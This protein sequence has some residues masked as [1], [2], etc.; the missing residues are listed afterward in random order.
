MTKGS[1]S[2]I[3]FLCHLTEHLHRFPI[4]FF[5]LFYAFASFLSPGSTLFSCLGFKPCTSCITLG[6]SKWKNSNPLTHLVVWC[7]KYL[8]LKL[9]PEPIRTSSDTSSPPSSLLSRCAL[10]PSLFTRFTS[11]IRSLPT[12]FGPTISSTHSLFSVL[13]RLRFPSLS[14]ATLLSAS[15]RRSWRSELDGR[16]GPRIRRDF[17]VSEVVV[18]VGP[19]VSSPTASLIFLLRSFSS[20]E[21]VSAN[22]HL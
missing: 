12:S 8:S 13:S 3:S 4:T 2:S 19:Y 18:G 15:S 20:A 11:S 17:W 9:P 1:I 7:K 16:E 14:A 10:S 5:D 21:L 6:K 22:V